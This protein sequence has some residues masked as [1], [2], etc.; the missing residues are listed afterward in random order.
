MRHM[1]WQIFLLYEFMGA[2]FIASRCWITQACLWMVMQQ[3]HLRFLPSQLWTINQEE[4]EMWRGGFAAAPR[5]ADDLISRRHGVQAPLLAWRTDVSRWEHYAYA[6]DRAVHHVSQL[7]LSTLQLPLQSLHVINSGGP[8]L[9]IL[10]SLIYADSCQGMW[11]LT[12]YPLWMLRCM[13]SEYLAENG[14]FMPARMSDRLVFTG[15]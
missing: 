6:E 7:W 13:L 9:Q 15:L 12:L 4:S 10:C 14:I 8:E 1:R 3:F 5:A 11:I 2:H